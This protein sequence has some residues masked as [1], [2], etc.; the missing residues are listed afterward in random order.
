MVLWCYDSSM[1]LAYALSFFTPARNY[2]MIGLGWA[3]SKLKLT[4]FAL[5]LLATIS[6]WS[7]LAGTLGNKSIASLSLCPLLADGKCLAVVRSCHDRGEP[8][9]MT[10]RDTRW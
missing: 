7:V 8:H 1:V 2:C 4:M 10:Q 6:R 5:K 9:V 3:A